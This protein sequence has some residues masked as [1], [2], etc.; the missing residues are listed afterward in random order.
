[1]AQRVIYESLVALVGT[2]SRAAA[3]LDLLARRPQQLGRVRL[4]VSSDNGHDL[5][6]D[7]RG[8]QIEAK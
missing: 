7:D 2:H 4:I 5:V 1:M 6:V 3:G 8:A